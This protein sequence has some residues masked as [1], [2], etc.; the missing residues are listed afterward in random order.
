MLKK[1]LG[2]L[3][4]Q[5]TSEKSVLDIGA[6]TGDFLALAKQKKWK[7]SG[8]EPNLKARNLAK[9]KGVILHDSLEDVENQFGI[10]TLW[11][12]LEHL[13]NLESQIKTIKSLL[14]QD[15]SLIIAVPNFKSFDASYYKEF[16]AAYDVPRHLWHFR[17][18]A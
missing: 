6:G 4:L 5:N 9:E 11:H 8:V 3:N 13:P 14:H 18:K 12:V 17:R 10:I 16:W 15:G 1:K 2:L 7:I